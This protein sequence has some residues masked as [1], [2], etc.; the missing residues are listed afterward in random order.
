MFTYYTNMKI[1]PCSNTQQNNPTFGSRMN[2]VHPFKILTPQGA[3]SIEEV[4]YNKISQKFIKN[5]TE[6]FCDNFS[7][8]TNDPNWLKYNRFSKREKEDFIDQFKQYYEYSITDP[9]EQH[10]TLLIAKDSNKNIQGAC[11]SFGCD[12]VPGAKYNTLYI[13]S[14]AVNKK[15]RGNNIAKIMLEKSI[16][17]GRHIFTDV[18]LTGEKVADGF[19]KK[20]GFRD[21]TPD[22]PNEAKII[23][24]VAKQRQDYPKY[25][26]FLTK[27]IQEKRP[28][29]YDICAK[30]PKLKD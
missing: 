25:T 13:D 14:L 6:F 28:R 21:L 15:Y 29:W 22:N 16:E 2:P 11:L 17:T 1:I 20:L 26:S 18:F 8:D 24:H 3:L 5:I 10:V 4:N 30:N 19:Y 9:S 23:N 27:P 12:D 7:K